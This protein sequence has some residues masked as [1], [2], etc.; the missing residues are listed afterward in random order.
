MI[1]M[2]NSVPEYG[3]SATNQSINLYL[4]QAKAHTQTR[5]RMHKTQSH[6]TTKESINQSHLH[7]NDQWLTNKVK[8]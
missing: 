6:Y 4:N 1:N 3:V 2:W 8:K 7:K 5:A